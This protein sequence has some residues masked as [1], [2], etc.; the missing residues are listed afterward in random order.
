MPAQNELKER[1]TRFQRIYTSISQPV[2]R[3][4]VI[5]TQMLRTTDFRST[6]KLTNLNQQIKI[7]FCMWIG[8][9]YISE[10]DT[11]NTNW[12]SQF[13]EILTS[14]T[15]SSTTNMWH[16]TFQYLKRLPRFLWTK[17]FGSL[18]WSLLS[19]VTTYLCYFMNLLMIFQMCRTSPTSTLCLSQSSYKNSLR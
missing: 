18:N 15:C 2:Y 16:T 6:V 11:T 14:S 10:S 13:V 19:G 4:K 17:H 3:S 9:W 7:A 12:K 5:F 8:N 1:Y